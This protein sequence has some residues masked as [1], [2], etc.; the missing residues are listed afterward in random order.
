M[1]MKR[2]R[3]IGRKAGITMGSESERLA[4][5]SHVWVRRVEESEEAMAEKSRCRDGGAGHTGL[6]DLAAGRL[7]KVRDGGA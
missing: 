4:G 5:E 6:L 1:S 7:E 2:G 3:V